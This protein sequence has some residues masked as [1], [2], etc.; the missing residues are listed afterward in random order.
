[1]KKK[2]NRKTSLKRF[3]KR[4]KSVRFDYNEL[5]ETT[6]E[7]KLRNCRKIL[8]DIK[9]RHEKKKGIVGM[10]MDIFKPKENVSG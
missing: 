8:Q 9:T 10:I 7:Q 6:D 1:M 5:E 4:H 3:L 2:K